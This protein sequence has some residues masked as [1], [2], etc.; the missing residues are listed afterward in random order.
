[1]F[2]YPAIIESVR[3]PRPT[4]DHRPQV[5]HFIY[6]F[7]LITQSFF[8]SA[9]YT[10][11][12][13]RDRETGRFSGDRWET[14]D[15]SLSPVHEKETKNPSSVSHCSRKGDKEP[16]LCLPLFTKRR[17]RTVPPSPNINSII[18]KNAS[19]SI[20]NRSCKTPVQDRGKEKQ[21][22][23]NKQD[24][25]SCPD[26]GTFRDCADHGRSDDGAES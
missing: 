20:V 17:Q 24:S 6:A 11:V 23:R 7:S 1:M 22:R 10:C 16:I 14:G 18:Q 15:G 12:L 19:L 9:S 25:H 21:G 5:H 3:N 4:E 2:F 26:T 13:R 8:H